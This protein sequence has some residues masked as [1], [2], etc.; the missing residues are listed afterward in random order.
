MPFFRIP[1]SSII[2]LLI[3][4]AK[5]LDVSTT[6]SISAVFREATQHRVRP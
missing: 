1:A 2:M 5:H 3:Y 4:V 6:L